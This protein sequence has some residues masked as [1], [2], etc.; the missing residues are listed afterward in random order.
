MWAGKYIVQF[1]SDFLK[2]RGEIC[3]KIA[4]SLAKMIPNQCNIKDRSLHVQEQ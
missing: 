3:K 4:H 2:N 1:A